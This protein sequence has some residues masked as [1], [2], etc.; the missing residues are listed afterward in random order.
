MA[1]RHAEERVGYEIYFFCIFSLLC[2]YSLFTTVSLAIFY[3]LFTWTIP[4]HCF[5]RSGIHR[6]LLFGDFEYSEEKLCLFPSLHK[7]HQPSHHL[8]PP[9][10]IKKRNPPTADFSLL[11]RPYFR[12]ENLSS[13][14]T[15]RLQQLKKVPAHSHPISIPRDLPSDQLE[16]CN[17]TDHDGLPSTTSTM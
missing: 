3:C 8:P 12:V 9:Q 6:A 1:L 7:K 2:P 5:W 13:Y 16:R 11:P 4:I 15:L 17:V 10:H 14:S